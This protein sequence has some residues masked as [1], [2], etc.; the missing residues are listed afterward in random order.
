M[1]VPA[2]SGVSASGRSP[3]WPDDRA[4]GVVQGTLAAVKPSEPFAFLGPMNVFLWASYNTELTVTSG[5]ATATVAAAGALAAG[6]AINSSLVPRGTTMS[7]IAGTDITLVLP[8]YTYWG[9]T[10]AGVAEITDLEDTTWLL[11][12]TVT[13]PGI[14]AATTVTAIDT[15]AIAG[16]QKGVV[17]ISAAPTSAPVLDEQSPFRFQ[18]VV[19]ALTSGADADAVFTGAAIVYNGTPQLERTFDGGATW[20]PCN[21]GSSGVLAQWAS[22]TTGGVPVSLSFGEPEQYVMYRINMLAYSAITGTTFNYRI[23]ETG[24]AARTLA[25]PTLT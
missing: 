4:N 2:P 12:A 16:V 14:P 7:A 9:K 6:S 24:Q 23:S 19:G 5:S 15:P 20:L 3:Y 13:G 8:A 18:I 17:T 11:G 21:M 22:G 1:G 25:V 10:K